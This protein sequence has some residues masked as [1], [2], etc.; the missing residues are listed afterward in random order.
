MI[1][2]KRGIFFILHFGRQANEKAIAPQPPSPGYATA[3][4]CRAIISFTLFACYA[5]T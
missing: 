4:E 5:S 3:A 1:S 2:E